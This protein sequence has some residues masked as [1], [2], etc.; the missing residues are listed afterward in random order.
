MG[1]DRDRWSVSMFR[2]RPPN[3]IPRPVTV[4][5]GEIVCP[6]FV[7]LHH[8]HNDPGI[9]RCDREPDLSR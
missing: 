7:T 6:T 3:E 2:R 5:V 4:N 8:C 1:A 9:R